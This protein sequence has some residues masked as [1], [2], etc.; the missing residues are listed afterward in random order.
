MHSFGTAKSALTRILKVCACD[1][2]GCGT[3]DVLTLHFDG[4]HLR[5]QDGAA[6]TPNASLACSMDAVFDGP[7]G[8]QA[9]GGRA[10]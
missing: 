8:L 10:D 6:H 2:Q 9:L 3:V 7:L 5:E 4:W 1:S